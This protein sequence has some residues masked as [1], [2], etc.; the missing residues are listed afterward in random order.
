MFTGEY[1]YNMDQKGRIS[2]PARYREELG[3]EF[4]LCKGFDKCLNIY[5]M[6]EWVAF[7]EKI[8][9]LPEASQRHVKRY[10]FSGSVEGILDAQGRIAIPPAYRQFASLEKDIVIIG[11]DNHIEIWAA[12]EWDKEQQF[13]SSEGITN[14]L[15]SCG[16]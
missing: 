1:W 11:N 9:A 2:V 15:I 16:F 12:S 6:K 13:M 3:G 4:K 7:A 10:F 14:D 5:P 8:Q